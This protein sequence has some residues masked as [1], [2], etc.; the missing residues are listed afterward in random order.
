MLAVTECWLTKAARWRRSLKLY[1]NRPTNHSLTMAALKETKV[2]VRL[3]LEDTRQG[4]VA[5]I[6]QRDDDGKTTERP[7]IFLVGDKE[8][9]KQRARAV[10]RALGLKTYRVLDRTSSRVLPSTHPA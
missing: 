7:S 6:S 10:A 9:A 1:T 5:T 4:L 2:F 3:K 8:E